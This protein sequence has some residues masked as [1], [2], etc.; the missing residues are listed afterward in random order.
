MV[1]SMHFVRVV[2]REAWEVELVEERRV[3]AY[4]DRAQALQRAIAA[5]PDWIELGEVVE[6]EGE[7]PRHHSWTTLR[8]GAAG[9]YVPSPLA[10]RPRQPG[11]RNP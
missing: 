8:R 11:P 1:E 7:S 5:E 10:W 3:L 6:A 2:Q 9:S 4:P